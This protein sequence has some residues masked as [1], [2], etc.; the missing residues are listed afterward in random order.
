[1]NYAKLIIFVF[2]FIL[3]VSFAAQNTQPLTLRYYFNWETGSFPM[4]LLMF[5][6]FFVGIVVGSLIAFG[7][8][9]RLKNTVKHLTRTNRDL[10]EELKR[11]REPQIPKG[12]ET[13]N[14]EE[15]P[16]VSGEVSIP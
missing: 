7:S 8:R 15:K 10:E 2:V 16:M 1:M 12:L 14:E 9:L 4:Y 13:T 11:V 3:A 5:I 6:P